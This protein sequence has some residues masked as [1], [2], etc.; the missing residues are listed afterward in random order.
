MALGL[1]MKRELTDALSNDTLVVA[2]SYFVMKFWY[3][4][5]HHF[6][7]MC[8]RGMHIIISHTYST[9]FNS[10]LVKKYGLPVVLAA[11]QPTETTEQS[12]RTGIMHGI[13]FVE[14]CRRL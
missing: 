8:A 13:Y 2:S 5:V 6:L 3:H 12:A 7:F 10:V 4:M 1:G 9:K 14:S 11:I